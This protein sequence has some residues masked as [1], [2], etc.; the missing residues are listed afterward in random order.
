MAKLVLF[1]TDQG[2][3]ILIGADGGDLPIHDVA[4][5]DC[6]PGSPFLIVDE[7]EL[8]TTDMYSASWEVDFSN[9]DGYGAGFDRWMLEQEAAR[10]GHTPQPEEFPVPPEDTP[11]ENE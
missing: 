11:E 7:S 9:P 1:D 10:F 6:P 8:P 5:K 3:G 2:V 4:R